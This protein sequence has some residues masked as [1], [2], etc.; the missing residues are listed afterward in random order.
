[1]LNPKTFLK[2]LSKF[3]IV[4]PELVNLSGLIFMFFS[5]EKYWS[6]DAQGNVS[7]RDVSLPSNVPPENKA[8]VTPR[9]A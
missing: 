7:F 1:M 3:S 2:N 9:A 4:F 6:Y 5:G 8:K